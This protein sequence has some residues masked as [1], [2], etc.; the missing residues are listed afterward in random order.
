MHTLEI[1]T[2]CHLPEIH[3]SVVENASTF[4]FLIFKFCCVV[5]EV[6]SSCKD[7]L[8]S[9]SLLIHRMSCYS[10]NLGSDAEKCTFG[11]G[12]RNASDKIGK[13][14]N[15]APPPQMRM[16]QKFSSGHGNLHGRVYFIIIPVCLAD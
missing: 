10:L 1:M 2:F 4:S 3:L 14:T 7:A 8:L 16:S 11:E 12:R 5:E 15:S 9:L 13:G 6:R